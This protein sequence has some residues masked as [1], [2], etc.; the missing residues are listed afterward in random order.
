M[1]KIANLATLAYA[2]GFTLWLYRHDGPMSDIY[3]KDFFFDAR[4]IRL[5]FERGFGTRQLGQRQAQRY[6]IVVT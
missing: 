1:F 5:L 4:H 3:H 6:R 2:Q